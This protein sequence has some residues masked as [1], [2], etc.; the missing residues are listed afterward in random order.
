[1]YLI[2]IG[3]PCCAIASPSALSALLRPI[4]RSTYGGEQQP[5]RN[6][7]IRTFLQW[8]MFRHVGE[9][10]LHKR[11]TLPSDIVFDHVQ[12]YRSNLLSDPKQYFPSHAESFICVFS[13]TSRETFNEMPLLLQEALKIPPERGQERIVFLVGTKVDLEQDRQVSH[14]EAQN[15]ASKMGIPYFETAATNPDAVRAIFFEMATRLLRGKLGGKW[16]GIRRKWTP[17][18]AIMKPPP[19]EPERKYNLFREFFSHVL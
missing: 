4:G 16:G 13:I 19:P 12:T 7:M 11:R 8:W 15:L 10:R 17:N 6:R 14:E 9:R 3:R 2:R 1:M 18:M 5:P